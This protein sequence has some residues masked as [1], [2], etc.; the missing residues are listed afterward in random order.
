MILAV[1]GR[2]DKNK[3]LHT[4]VKTFGLPSSCSVPIPGGDRLIIVSRIVD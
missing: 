2:N 4:I 3:M 1:R